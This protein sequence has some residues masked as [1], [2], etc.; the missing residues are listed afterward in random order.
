MQQC[1]YSEHPEVWNGIKDTKFD[2][3]DKTFG[4]VC[5]AVK[6]PERL[7]LAEWRY[8]NCNRNGLI[9]LQWLGIRMDFAL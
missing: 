4:K 7:N 1:V 3:N 6:T 9:D 8:S 2:I 5:I